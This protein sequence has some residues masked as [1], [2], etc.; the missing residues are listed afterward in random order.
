MDIKSSVYNWS[1]FKVGNDKNDSENATGRGIT[2]APGN[3]ESCSTEIRS[4]RS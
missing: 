2:I 4:Y 3:L 1:Q